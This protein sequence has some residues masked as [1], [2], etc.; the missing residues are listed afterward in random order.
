M[1]KIYGHP[2]AAYCWKAEIACYER[3]VDFEFRMLDP[4]HPQHQAEVA[5]LTP[6]GQFPVLVEGDRVVFETAQIIEYLDLHHGDA[7]PMVPAD[8]HEALEARMMDGVFDDYVMNVIQEMV[9]ARLEGREV[10]P[11]DASA[12]ARLDKAYAWLDGWLQTREWAACGRFTIAD[13]AAVPALHYA[14]WGHPIPEAHV[15]LHAYRRRIVARPSAA[16]A[17]EEAKPWREFY[18]L[19]EFG[20]PD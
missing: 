3:G 4:D 1:L 16:R 6:T 19:K 11:V 5:G 15:A 2:F 13:I 10:A 9:N 17:I 14:H 12:R 8:P 20:S 7:P 18:P